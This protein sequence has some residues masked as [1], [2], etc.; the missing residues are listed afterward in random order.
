MAEQAIT[1]GLIDTDFRKETMTGNIALNV[2]PDSG[3][4]TISA[5]GGTITVTTYS[6]DSVEIQIDFGNDGVIDDNQFTTWKDLI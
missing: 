6:V 3:K 5:N 1:S 4:F 2:L